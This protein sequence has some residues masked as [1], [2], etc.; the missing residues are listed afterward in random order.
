[1]TTRHSGVLVRSGAD[2]LRP[3]PRADSIA[4]DMFVLVCSSGFAG[5]VICSL[6]AIVKPLGMLTIIHTLYKQICVF[7]KHTT[8][9][10]DVCE[11]CQLKAGPELIA[12]SLSANSMCFYEKRSYCADVAN[13][14]L[15]WA[16]E[17]LSTQKKP[18]ESTN[19]RIAILLVFQQCN[20][21]RDF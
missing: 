3:A 4:S 12:W 2:K 16:N 13:D 19:N 1:M 15:Q 6:A 5:I 11:V 10:R 18:T 20:D 9:V 8:A 17:F 7:S 14:G 21:Y